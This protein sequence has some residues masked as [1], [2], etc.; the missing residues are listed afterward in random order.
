M[1]VDK[2][3]KLGAECRKKYEIIDRINGNVIYLESKKSV[4]DYCGCDEKT[5]YNAL[6]S[7]SYGKKVTDRFDIKEI[8][9]EF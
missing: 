3:K 7:K 5:I 6:Y 8:K 4:A 1:L 2:N 9:S